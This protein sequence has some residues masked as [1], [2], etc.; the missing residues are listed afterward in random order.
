MRRG[1]S[2]IV[3]PKRIAKELFSIT[4][5]WDKWRNKFIKTRIYYPASIKE[6]SLKAFVKYKENTL[7]RELGVKYKERLTSE[8]I[9]DFWISVRKPR[10]VQHY[11]NKVEN[12]VITSSTWTKELPQ[13]KWSDGGGIL[14]QSV[15]DALLLK[16][17]KTCLLKGHL[18]FKYGSGPI[19]IKQMHKK[20][21][22]VVQKVK[23]EPGGD[24]F[25]DPIKHDRFLVPGI[26]P[27]QYK[28]VQVMANPS[29]IGFTR[30]EAIGAIVQRL[31]I[32]GRFSLP[33]I[34]EEIGPT[35]VY[36]VETNPS[37]Y[38][39]IITS[40]L[41]HGRHESD[42]KY[43]RPIAEKLFEFTREQV[44]CDKVMWSLGGRVRR[45][46]RWKDAPLRG[47]IMMMPEG[48]QKILGLTFASKIYEGLSDL[49]YDNPINEIQIGRN[50]FHGNYLEYSKY[51]K[52]K[53]I[54]TLEADIKM[55]D[56][57]CSE[58]VLIL[59]FSII[60][61]CFREGEDFDNIFLYIMSGTIFKNLA[62]P[63]RL[64][65]KI[66]KGIPSGSSFTSLLVSVVNW[67]H[68]TILIH[69]NFPGKEH[70][71]I[72]HIFGDDTLVNL[73]DWCRKSEEWWSIEFKRITT[74]TLDPCEIRTFHSKKYWKRPSFLKTVPNFDLPCRTLQHT[75][76]SCSFVRFRNRSWD[77]YYKHLTVMLYAS[78]FYSYRVVI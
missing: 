43:I 24:G 33:K 64:V 72:L 31:Q 11:D 55:H 44:C 56:A 78:P 63:G 7:S 40:R 38:S 34:T 69:K 12:G 77:S 76:E 26:W 68:W 39:G 75:L 16:T 25:Y 22:E 30:E 52:S 32:K 67:I 19:K 20:F 15:R 3:T 65:Y 35:D 10:T 49:N 28:D 61:S 36:R 27:T 13:G 2:G 54:N 47:R 23:P 74:M 42:D 37:A 73:P 51:F 18:P 62:V 6:A 14:K 71:F 21:F 45:Q 5:K 53:G 8:Q 48:P 58:E 4:E 66:L 17:S 46:K 59:A 9:E 50:D 60:R 1:R 57:H 41:F 29:T 70:E